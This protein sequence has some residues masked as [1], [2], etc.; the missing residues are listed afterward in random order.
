MNNNAQVESPKL[1]A[2]GSLFLQYLVHE[3]L[4]FVAKRTRQ[5]MHIIKNIQSCRSVPDLQQAYGEFWQSAFTQYAEAPRRMM[6]VT[7]GGVDETSPGAQRNGVT[8][9]TLH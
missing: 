3:W 4:E 6:L 8:N 2:Q 9:A 7:Q 1:N 5:H